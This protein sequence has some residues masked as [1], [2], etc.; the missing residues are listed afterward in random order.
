MSTM[1]GSESRS[2]EQRLETVCC[3]CRKV[4]TASGEW[5][6]PT[7]PLPDLISHGICRA[8]LVI[9]YPDVPPPPEAS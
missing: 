5:S 4:R 9:H 6:D 2:C 1:M 3:H 8:C 7:R